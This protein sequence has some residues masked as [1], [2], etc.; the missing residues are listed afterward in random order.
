LKNRATLNRIDK[1]G[2]LRDKKQDALDKRRDRP[3]RCKKLSTIFV[4][5]C[6]HSLRKGMVSRFFESVFCSAI[7]KHASIL[8]IK[9]NDLN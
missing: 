7:K 6:V 1:R 8:S 9:T 3:S 4:D 2:K 5:N